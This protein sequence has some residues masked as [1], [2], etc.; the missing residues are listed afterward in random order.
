MT[1]PPR[2]RRRDHRPQSGKV[3]VRISPETAGTLRVLA[4]LEARHVYQVVEAAVR[5]YARQ[6]HADYAAGLE[7]LMNGAQAR[8]EEDAQPGDD[9]P[10]TP[11]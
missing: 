8:R 1:S 3:Q 2:R 10:G 7:A 4:G 5:E 9:A 11:T 6:H